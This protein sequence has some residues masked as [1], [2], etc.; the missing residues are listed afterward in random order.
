M[1]YV[2]LGAFVALVLFS[3]IAWSIQPTLS[4]DGR[5]PLVWVSDDNPA[6]RD[7]IALFNNLNPTCRLRLDPSNLGMEKTIVQSL[8][9]AGPDLFNTYGGAQLAAYVRSGIAWDITDELEKK[10]IHYEHEVWP[11]VSPTFVYDGRAYGY[12]TNVGADALWLHKDAFESEGIPIPTGPWT[13]KEFLPLAQKLTK[14]NQAGRIE[15]YGILIPWYRWPQFIMQWGGRIYTEDGTRCVIDSP[16]AVA[17]IQF[18]QDL[19]YLYKVMPSPVDEA[20]MATAGGW[21]SGTITLFGAKKAAMAMGGRWW[22]CLLRESKDLHLG[23]VEAPFGTRRVFLG[24]GKGTVIN[25]FSPRREEALA[26]LQYLSGKSYNDLINHQADALAPVKAY[27]YTDNYLHDP[28]FPDEDYNDVWRD[29]MQYAF[30]EE[31]SPYVNNQVA[32][33]IFDMQM[34]LIKGRQ[35]PVA[36]AL[37]SAAEKVNEE[38]RKNL[39]LDP[40]LRAQYERA[41]GK[42][43]R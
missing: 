35:K 2:F 17:G 15:R 4:D 14:R 21:G 24:Y 37:H 12:P 41:V 28:A 20:A 1:K 13:W 42:S 19:M 22:L 33:R 29:V 18:F 38:I 5:T 36:D 7:Q 8:A 3:V 31:I 11:A 25:Q 30:P 32:A 39:E 43:A 16:E 26:F 40:E 9:G 6:R 10:G 23:A 34:D 27:S